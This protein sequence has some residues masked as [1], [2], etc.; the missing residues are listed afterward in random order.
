ML[1][2]SRILAVAAL[3]L[4]VG[5]PGLPAAAAA[6]APS[7][8]TLTSDERG[9][10]EAAYKRRG[11]VDKVRPLVPEQYALQVV[12]V[13][14]AGPRVDLLINEVSCQQV[15]T[16]GVELP[17]PVVTVIVSTLVTAPDGTDSAYV[18]FY[19]TE[20]LV[21]SFALNRLG[22]PADRLSQASSSSVTR[23]G[24]GQINSLHLTVLGSGWNHE[25][26]VAAT[27]PGEPVADPT[28][29]LRDVGGA[30]LKLCYENHFSRAPATVAGDLT[31]TPLASVTS[32]PPLLKHEFDWANRAWLAVGSQV[33]TLTSGSCPA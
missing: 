27:G 16:G 8:V 25:L 2:R 13:T 14:S 23:D 19:A 29:Y 26:T 11:L 22:W 28:E 18:L 12:D 3:M 5:A 31:K 6:P 1:R 15:T 21:Q 33:S 32:A 9:C 20:N 24:T 10:T 17:G 7:G 4:A 30:S